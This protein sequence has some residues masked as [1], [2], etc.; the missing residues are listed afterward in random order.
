M[1]VRWAHKLC[2][3]ERATLPLSLLC[4]AP[5]EMASSRIYKLDERNPYLNNCFPAKNLLQ[6][7]EEGQVISQIGA[8][9][10][11]PAHILLQ[12]VS[13][14][15][16]FLS[17]PFTTVPCPTQSHPFQSISL[18]Q[19]QGTS[20]VHIRPQPSCSVPSHCW[21]LYLLFCVQSLTSPYPLLQPHSFI[22]ALFYSA[23][24]SRS[25]FYVPRMFQPSFQLSR[26]FPPPQNPA[27][28]PLPPISHVWLFHPRVHPPL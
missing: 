1:V 21:L 17:C 25:F 19:L 26:L 23:V 11:H 15:R 5:R 14:I 22:Y 24:F 28:L 9:A 6:T 27:L 7:P 3:K 18:Q 20:E 13:H 16:S 8:F 4:L 10:S 2:W 12:N